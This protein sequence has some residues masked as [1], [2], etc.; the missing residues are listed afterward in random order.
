[1]QNC[2]VVE[3]AIGTQARYKASVSTAMLC[4]AKSVSFLQLIINFNLKKTP[5][6]PGVVIQMLEIEDLDMLTDSYIINKIF[7]CNIFSFTSTNKK[8]K[9]Y[10]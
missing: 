9:E 7:L 8:I 5:A 6:N 4:R 1:M 2:R 3:T 10:F